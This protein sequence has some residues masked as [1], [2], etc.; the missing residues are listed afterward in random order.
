MDYILYTRTDI[1]VDTVVDNL[2]ELDNI[3]P[4]LTAIPRIL[5]LKEIGISNEEIPNILNKEMNIVTTKTQIKNIL[6]RM[7]NQ[8]F[9][10]KY[11]YLVLMD[12]D[13][14]MSEDLMKNTII[15]HNLYITSTIIA[16]HFEWGH[17]ILTP[18]NY[19][20]KITTEEGAL[21]AKRLLKQY[22]T[23]DKELLE[24]IQQI[25]PSVD[26]LEKSYSETIIQLHS[27]LNNEVLE[28]IEKLKRYA[29][30]LTK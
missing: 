20:Y 25:N 28:W 30:E 8:Q 18:K 29:V 22:T 6:A 12:L 15:S 5:T 19:K 10:K 11:N 26:K 16:R 21:Y 1:G 14:Q 17:L 27:N 23:S 7:K 4:I 13:L 3:E 2:K 24:E 9:K